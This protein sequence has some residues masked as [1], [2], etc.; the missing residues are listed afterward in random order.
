MADVRAELADRIARVAAD[1]ESGASDIL[2][3][4]IGIL[5]TARTEDLPITPVASALCRAQPTMASVWN[6]A[7]EAVAS[8]H[9]PGRFDRFTQRVSRAGAALARFAVEGFSV[10]RVSGPLRL[11]TISSSRSVIA[12]IDA[13]RRRR[14]VQLA[15]SES[16]PAL[17][18][19]RLAGRVASLGVPVTCFSDA[20][21]GHALA[22]ADAV[23]L[24]ADA[25]GP[26]WFLNKIGSKMLAAAA[27]QHGVPVYVAATR[28][29]FV[30]EAVAARLDIRHGSAR[31]IWET[32]PSGVEICNP[33]FEST[34]LDL[35]TAIISDAGLLGAGM[36][37]E[38]CESLH[39]P[40]IVA[41]LDEVAM[42]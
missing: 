35:V 29:K 37:P 4:V 41:A 38:V 14:P 32:P 2:D 31:E 36:V 40:A 39:D 3:E 18:G 12:V 9:D 13:V 30:S 33:Y 15:C 27:Q 22:A 8:Q 16:R 10:D 19:R 25:I 34:P 26:E 5:T 23:V 21:I 42:P 7:L 1:R 17:E 20:A 11:V 24:G 6:A 28:D